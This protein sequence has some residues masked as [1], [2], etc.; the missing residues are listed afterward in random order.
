MKCTQALYLLLFAAFSAS[1]QSVQIVTTDITH[2]WEAHDRVLASTD[3]LERIDIMQQ[4]YVDRGS[5]GLRALMEVRDYTTAEL[6]ANVH[7]YRRYW[8]SIRPH[9]AALTQDVALIEDYLGRLQLAYPQMRKVPIYFAIGGF[10]TAGTYQ[11]DKLLL[12]AEILMAKPGAVIDE[13]PERNQDGLRNYMPFNIPLIA[14][15]EFVHVQQE[16]GWEQYSVM[17][18]CVGEGVAEFVST[19]L[20]GTPLSPPVVFGK[21]HAADVLKVF[22]EEV[23]R[24][25]APGNWLS[26][27]NRNRLVQNDLGYYIGYAICERFYEAAA[28]KEQALRQLIDLN[29][30]D[31]ATFAAFLDGSG[32]LPETWAQIGARYEAMRPSITGLQPFANGSMAVS[33]KQ[34][35]LV[36]EFSEPM[37]SCCRSADY[38]TT[39]GVV[40][41][42]IKS[43]G[44]WSADGRSLRIELGPL[45]PETTYGLVISN[46]AKADG[47]NRLAPYTIRF[48]TGKR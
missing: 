35:Q 14:L 45:Q 11:P 12:G 46:F 34:T 9:A 44:S 10:R 19:Q 33:P 37:S 1:G 32:F 43:W 6:A 42:P 3:S 5:A 40:P 25:D 21:A 18:R 29:Y 36:I 20:A 24:D 31:E 38:D 15:H 23:V 8:E 41:L 47:Y 30:A 27:Q 4:L 2:Y 17:H 13:L 28:D 26:G 39:A 16:A 48:R 7:K 22:M